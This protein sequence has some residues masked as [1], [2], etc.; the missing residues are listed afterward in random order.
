MS[1]SPAQAPLSSTKPTWPDDLPP[2]LRKRAEARLAKLPPEEQDAMKARMRAMAERTLAVNP[3]PKPL[4][5]G[6]V[7]ETPF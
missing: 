2:D 4:Q 5:D 1:S 3:K 6:I 7:S